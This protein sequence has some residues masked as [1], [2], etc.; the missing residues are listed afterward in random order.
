VHWDEVVAIIDLDS[1]MI[2]SKGI[3]TTSSGA[4]LFYVIFEQEAACYGAVRLK[5]DLQTLA[6]ERERLTE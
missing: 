6:N 4:L 1:V 5:S 3:P 2:S